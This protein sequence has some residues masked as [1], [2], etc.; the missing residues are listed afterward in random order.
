MFHQGTNI[1][2]LNPNIHFCNSSQS[3]SS[4]SSSARKSHKPLRSALFF[5]F[6][7]FSQLEVLEKCPGISNLIKDAFRIHLSPPIGR[8]A[9]IN[10]QGI[11]RQP[12]GLTCNVL[13]VLPL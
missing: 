3:Y 4:A 10:L 1:C 6:H 13:L 9:C 2:C 7:F 11:L 8:P 5:F 12:S